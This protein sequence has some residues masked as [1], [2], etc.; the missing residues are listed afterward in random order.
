MEKKKFYELLIRAMRITLAQIV[1]AVCFMSIGLARTAEAQT[2]LN[3]KIY[4]QV[5]D[6]SFSKVLKGIEKQ[7]KIRFVY[8]SKLIKSDRKTSISFVGETLSNVLD[9]LLLPRQLDYE[10]TGNMIIL[11]KT[12]H[13]KMSNM[14]VLPPKIIESIREIPAFVVS[15]IITDEKGEPLVGASVVLKGTTKGTVTDE[16]GKYT[17]DLT[18]ADKKGT[19]IVSFVGYDN[20]SIDIKER[21][22]INI[23]LEGGKALDEVVV[24]GYGS[25]K[26][27]DLTGSVSSVKVDDK[28]ASQTISMDK[29]L[30]GRAAGVDVISGN[31]A[32]GA[33]INV[34]IRGTGTLTGNTEP[35]YVVDGIIMNTANQEVRQASNNGN[36]SQ[37]TQNGLTALNPQDIESM[38]I[39]KDASATAIYGSR[40]ANGVVLITTKKG[41]S[42][43]TAVNF[44]ANTELSEISKRLDVLDGREF[45]LYDNEYTKI[46]NPN[47]IPKYSETTEGLDSL[48][49]IDWQDYSYRRAVSQN[50][51]LSFAGQVQKTNFYLAA[52]FSDFQ[53][54][55][56]NSGLKKGDIKLN[57]IH[58]VNSRLKISSNSSIIYQI[59][60]WVQGTERLGGANS[61]LIRAIIRKSPLIGYDENTAAAEEFVLK[62]SPETWFQQFEDKSHEFRV[63]S[64]L[65]FDYK[66]S[67]VFSYKLVLG[68][69]Y[70]NKSRSQYFGTGLFMG[71]TTNGRAT[72]SNLEYTSAEIQNL[73]NIKPKLGRS[74]NLLGTIG[75]TYDTN[76]S[77][78][79]AS[80]AENFFT[81]VLGVDGFTLG[82][83]FNP[84]ALNKT[85]VSVMSALA[86]ANYSYKNR[87]YLTMTG[88][89]DGSSR[90]AEGNKFGFFP[91]FVFAWRASNERFLKNVESI[92]DLKFRLGWGQTGVQTIGAYSTKLLY[93]TTSYPSPTGS[94]QI[95]QTVA[96]IA[97]QALTWET[98][99]QSNLGVDIGLLNNRL[100]ITADIYKK[101]SIDLLQNF[102]I[103]PSNGFSNVALNFG[104]IENKGLEIAADAIIL[105]KTVRWSLGGNITFNR[106]KLVNLGLQPAAWGTQ[107]LIAYTGA[108]IS[109]SGLNTPANLFVEGQPVGTFWGLK[110]AGIIQS[111]DTATVTYKGAKQVPGDIKFIDQNKDGVI[112]DLD[113]TF[114]GNPNPQFSYGIN[115]SVSYKR[116]KLDLF[117]TGVYGRDVLNANLLTE[118]YASFQGQNIRRE[119][120]YEAWRPNKESTTFPRIGYVSPTDVTDR[121][122]EDASY[123]RLSNINISYQIPFKNSKSL[124]NLEVFVSGRNLFLITKYSGFDPDVNSY[125]FNGSLIGVDWNSY[126]NTKAVTFGISANF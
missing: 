33:A 8:S 4:L 53:G 12:E 78:S 104:S 111:N 89:V 22:L 67:N 61:S 86:R 51:R 60:N 123:L 56:K 122:I 66:L 58:E 36:Y 39:L 20:Q 21:N 114:L 26:K 1:L 64:S 81:P 18:D 7:T 50:Y 80:T 94:L 103:A 59:N 32:P 76:L 73:L 108:F 48:K 115:T 90:F 46:N 93:N 83:V 113:K 37:E 52:G 40:G 91:S 116:V 27:S 84:L 17:L 97:N 109:T 98:S 125:T 45:A 34:R 54:V 118:N 5:Q 11:K 63:L 57:L 49:Y 30:Q 65:N 14:D 88:R 42:G 79:R 70:R 10:V 3:Q 2:D 24:V 124:S 31:G 96:R 44:R 9:N 29:L 77:T 101:T 43:K 82:Q 112:N 71:S 110:T 16:N 69:D 41:K 95:G 99:E 23:I 119:T 75:L 120:Y 62:E 107:Q 106:N 19:L 92:S 85:Q 68:G 38:E 47:A 6:E 117:F 25:V 105:D 28:V 72:Y 74:H 55:I 121:F 15:G 87:Y 13:L 126:P 102:P 35:L 100:K